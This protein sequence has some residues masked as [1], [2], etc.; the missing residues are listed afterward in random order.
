MF[1]FVKLSY[2]SSHD[3]RG[4]TGQWRITSSLLGSMRW[5]RVEASVVS[6]R[7]SARLL[8]ALVLT[9]LAHPY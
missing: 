4:L 5:L 7:S 3:R 6:F 8:V 9:A 2:Q 1:S